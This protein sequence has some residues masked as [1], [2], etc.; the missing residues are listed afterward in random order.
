MGV[1]DTE[2][3]ALFRTVRY[4]Y[5]ETYEWVRHKANWEHMTVGAVCMDY[6]YYIKELMAIE[7]GDN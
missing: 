3:M 5:P 1:I 6:R 7:D 2:A 4:Q